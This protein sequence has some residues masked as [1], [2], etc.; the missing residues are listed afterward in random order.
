MKRAC[1]ATVVRYSS[2]DLAKKLDKRFQA[3]LQHAQ[4]F[5]RNGSVLG[6]GSDIL[7]EVRIDPALGLHVGQFR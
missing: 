7:G 6:V 3:L 5:G 1:E 2:S 4:R